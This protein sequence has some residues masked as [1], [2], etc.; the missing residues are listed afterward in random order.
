MVNQV[1][2]FSSFSSTNWTNSEGSHRLPEINRQVYGLYS[3]VLET[4]LEAEGSM[5]LHDLSHRESLRA[6]KLITES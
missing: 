5:T 4:T 2:R 1:V 3:T 6:H